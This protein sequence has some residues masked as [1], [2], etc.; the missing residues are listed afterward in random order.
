MSVNKI[1]VIVFLSLLAICALP[2]AAIAQSTGSDSG[3]VTCGFGTQMCTLSDFIKLLI[4]VVRFLVFKIG[5]PF[6]IVAIMWLG[7]RM[8]LAQ[9][10]EGEYK[11][12]LKSLRNVLIGFSVIIICGLI[13]LTFLKL[14]QVKSDFILPQIRSGKPIQ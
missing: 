10:N 13:V 14:L 3:L 11:A 4:N 1:N 9:G 7:I 6:A 8:V 12:A 5:V 2:V